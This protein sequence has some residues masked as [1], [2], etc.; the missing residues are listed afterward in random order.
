[1]TAGEPPNGGSSSILAGA[2]K[3]RGH[4][5]MPPRERSPA[6]LM[7]LRGLATADDRIAIDL[8]HAVAE[9]GGR[10]VV[11]SGGGGLVPELTRIG[12]RHVFLPLD[13][14][15]PWTIRANARRVAKLAADERVQLIHARGRSAAWSGWLASRKAGTRF[16]TT[17][18]SPYGGEAGLGRLYAAALTRGERVIAVSGFVGEHLRKTFGIDDRR[19]RIVPRGIDMTRFDP[20]KVTAERVIDLS[21]RWQLP[22]GVPVVALPGKATPQKNQLLLLEALAR[23]P[24]RE[25]CCLLV[26]AEEG[27]DA[28]RRD[29]EASGRNLPGKR[30]IILPPC[31]DMA[32]AY[33][34]SDVV[35]S[36]AYKPD[37]FSL[38]IA[39]AQAMGRPVVVADHGAAREQIAHSPM[40]WGFRPNDPAALAEALTQAL[41]LSPTQRSHR[42]NDV[43]AVVRQ[44]YAKPQMCQA[45]LEVY[46]ELLG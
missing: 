8:A 39:E 5:D 10:T 9:A 46:R 37:A 12:A 36:A 20:G 41:D 3:E 29:I 33:M 24:Q 42:A 43:I 35:V 28:Y 44:R 19:L 30:V 4:R 7:L 6:V 38:V 32:A 25:L 31:R 40:A 21:T 23:L 27:E 1:M 15:N 13:S 16:V 26:G 45:T 14:R 2:P 34:L 18:D 17:V 22:D 11:A